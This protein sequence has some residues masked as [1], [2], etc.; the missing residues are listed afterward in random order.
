[1]QREDQAMRGKPLSNVDTA[2]W[3]MDDPSN[4]MMITAVAVLGAP[5]D[6]DRFGATLEQGL[7][8]FDRFRQRIVASRLC[9]GRYRWVEHQAFAVDEH[10]TQIELAPPGGQAALQDVVSELASTPLDPA[11][12][13][14]H[15]HV[16]ENYGPGCALIC[17]FHHCIGDGFAM[18]H[19][20][21]SLTDAEPGDSPPL[22]EP[23]ESGRRLMPGRVLHRTRDAALA[24]YRMKKNLVRGGWGIVA[25]PS[26]A[27]HAGADGALALGRL[28][29]R[30]PD[31]KTAFKGDLGEPK[32]AA[33]SAPIPLAEVKAVGRGLG[34]TVNDVLLAAVSGA[35]RGYL[36]DHGE[37]EGGR[38]FRAIVPVNLRTA[39]VGPELGNR[40]GL[41]FLALPVG[42][43]DPLDRL[44]ETRRRMDALKGSREAPV[45][46]GILNVMGLSLPPVQDLAVDL[47]A[48][49]GTAVMTNVIGPGEPVY[50]AGAPVESLMFWVPQ[51]GRLG[52]GV[53][54]L[55]YAGRVWIGVITDEGLAPDPEEI[56]AGFGAEFAELQKLAQGTVQAPDL[57]RILDDLDRVD[58]ELDVLL[59]AR[60]RAAADG[61]P[62]PAQ[63]ALCQ[64]LTRAGKPCKNRALPGSA[65]C[66]V[67]GAAA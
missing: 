62:E 45:A 56:V 26:R 31:P 2:W 4:L 1:M 50:L 8:R 29:L 65:Y 21:L 13:L 12:P 41:V 42:V 35:L 46:F 60:A 32:R 59:E 23:R 6:L 44:A 49:K 54:I 30:W 18:I 5:L 3:R 47:F 24:G 43:A 51:S 20:L 22:A 9:L 52:M 63:P 40:F 34:G 67:H 58:S 61:A 37:P 7:G 19:V 11:R 15:M 17:R 36:Q 64:A 16:V 10:I 33:W 25:H 38:D 57:G 48:T 66:Y 27:V 53:S 14:W 28:V 55:S 39:P